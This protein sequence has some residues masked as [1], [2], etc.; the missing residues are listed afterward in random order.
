MI[1]LIAEVVNEYRL[2][3]S[4]SVLARVIGYAELLL[5]RCFDSILHSLRLIIRDIAGGGPYTFKGLVCVCVFPPP[6]H[7]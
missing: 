1:L 2:R 4:L 7:L 3:G 5:V 6:G